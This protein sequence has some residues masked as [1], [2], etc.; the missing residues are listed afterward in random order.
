MRLAAGT[1]VN[2]AILHG[3]GTFDNTD[4]FA[5]VGGDGLVQRF[6]GLMTGSGHD[7]LMIIDRQNI[8]DDLADG[9]IGRTQQRLGVAG[10]ILE[11]QPDQRRAFDLIQSLGHRGA[12]EAGSA[13][14]AVMA[15]QNLR[16]SRRDTPR[17]LRISPTE[18]SRFSKPCSVLPDTFTILLL[19]HT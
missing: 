2:T 6:F 7:G 12:N 16:K 14:A 1:A 4:V 5:L 11:L 8:E 15:E 17:C 3:D 9:R 10:A 13:I 18:Y 19:T